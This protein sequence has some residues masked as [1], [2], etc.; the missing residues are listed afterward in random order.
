MR[1]FLASGP[2]GAHFSRI[3]MDFGVNN[4]SSKCQGRIETYARNEG[5]TYRAIRFAC[6]LTITA[7][8]IA[9]VRETSDPLAVDKGHLKRLS[10]TLSLQAVSENV[11]PSIT[12]MAHMWKSLAPPQ[13][14]ASPQ[15]KGLC[16]KYFESM[17]HD[18]LWIELVGGFRWIHNILPRHGV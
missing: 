11:D 4:S 13:P 17:I 5:S 10:D 8:I 12:A 3:F 6:N 18:G 2:A 16:Q 1:D 14:E 15:G 9:V 7:P